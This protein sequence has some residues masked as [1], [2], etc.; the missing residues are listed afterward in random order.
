MLGFP[1]SATN[2]NS[3]NQKTATH[4]P[5]KKRNL[6]SPLAI[7]RDNFLASYTGRTICD[8]CTLGADSSKRQYLQN[9]IEVAFLAGHAAA[10]ATKATP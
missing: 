1:A 5:A 9:R 7:A 3:M 10:M 8:P 4:T 6:R 2:R